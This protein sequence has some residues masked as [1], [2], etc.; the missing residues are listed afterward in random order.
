MRA[1]VVPVTVFVLAAACQ[2]VVSDA[3]AV[4]T[5]RRNRSASVVASSIRDSANLTLSPAAA[6]LGLPPV[7]A[8]I[9]TPAED[10]LVSQLESLYAGDPRRSDFRAS[11]TDPRV[12]R[13]RIS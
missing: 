6:S 8:M 11:L 9:L 10:R 4:D 5:A 7:P 3:P 13:M 1:P 2:T 12:G